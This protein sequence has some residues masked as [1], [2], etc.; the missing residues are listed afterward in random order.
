MCTAATAH[1]GDGSVAR[2]A[3]FVAPAS[4][5]CT[6]SPQQWCAWHTL[7]QSAFWLLLLTAEAATRVLDRVSELEGFYIDANDGFRY[8]IARGFEIEEKQAWLKES[9]QDIVN[10]YF[11]VSF[12][13]IICPNAELTQEG[14]MY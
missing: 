6:Q 11:L 1:Y 8:E 2:G 4:S 13:T 10:L 9:I 5:E 14:Y 3:A 12:V 7:L